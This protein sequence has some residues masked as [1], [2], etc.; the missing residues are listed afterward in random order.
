MGS[1]P[2]SPGPGHGAPDL[3]HPL[4]LVM[5]T[6]TSVR[7][8]S[9]TATNGACCARI[10]S[11][12]SPASAPQACGRSP[13][14]G[15]AAQVW[16]CFGGAGTPPG[17]ER[18]VKARECGGRGLSRAKGGWLGGVWPPRHPASSLPPQMRMNVTP[19]PACAPT[20]AVSTLWAASS[21]TVMR[22]SSSA[23]PAPSAR[24]SVARHGGHSH[25]HLPRSSEAKPPDTAHPRASSAS[26]PPSPVSAMPQRQAG[27]Q[28]RP[29]ESPAASSA[30]RPVLSAS[31]QPL[32]IVPLLC[33]HC[34][35]GIPAPRAPSPVPWLPR[36]PLTSGSRPALSPQGLSDPKRASSRAG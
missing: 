22:A 35:S 31:H 12:P 34:L 25:P 3:G 1:R 18:E 21:V 28:A 7:T 29:L 14:P 23:L 13:T 16:G 2:H 6:W 17:A 4:S 15:T 24:V 9:R 33:P 36:C 8:V 27:P 10:S 5:Q 32:G 30:P 11:A 20:V 26:C 19:S